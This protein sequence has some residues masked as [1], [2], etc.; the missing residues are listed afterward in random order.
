MH[1]F[2]QVGDDGRFAVGD[3]RSANGTWVNRERLEPGEKRQI[4]VG[5]R[6]A[7][8]PL[9]LMVV[10]GTGL[11]RALMSPAFATWEVGEALAAR[12]QH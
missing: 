7:F 11:F 8:G 9:N 4:G 5:D 12:R 2:F 6:I 1:A 3:H 10:D